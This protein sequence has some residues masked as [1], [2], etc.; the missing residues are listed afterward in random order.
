TEQ[1]NDPDIT[2]NDKKDYA[3]RMMTS[4]EEL[5]RYKTIKPSTIKPVKKKT[6]VEPPTQDTET[7]KD[8]DTEMNQV[9]PKEIAA[10][11]KVLEK[12]EKNKVKS[13]NY[14]EN[15]TEKMRALNKKNYEKNKESIAKKRLIAQVK[16]ERLAGLNVTRQ[17]TLNK[18]GITEAD[19]A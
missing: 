16:A 11:T 2:L 8:P 6:V 14:Y 7:E 18:Y 19:L 4:V 3:T 5:E 12:R 9:S 13:S 1:F 10:I 17:S 15:N